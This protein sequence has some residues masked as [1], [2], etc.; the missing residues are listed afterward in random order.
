MM[1]TFVGGVIYENQ[2]INKSLKIRKLVPSKEKRIAPDG[3]CLFSSISYIITGSDHNHRE[4]R[5]LL[6]LNMQGKYR[7]C[8]SKYCNS[9]SNLIATNNY[10]SI[11]EYIKS[12]LT[13]LD[14]GEPTWNY[15]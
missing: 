11:E 7:D 14:L 6:V 9:H 1:I 12:R 10:S 8:C 2:A 5:E 15:F 3:N 4:I 13:E